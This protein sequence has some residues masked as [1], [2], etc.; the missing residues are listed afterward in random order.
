MK[1]KF[2]IAVSLIAIFTVLFILPIYFH[3]PNY[4]GSYNIEDYAELIEIGGKPERN[5]GNIGNSFQASQKGISV[6]TTQFPHVKERVAWFSWETKYEIYRDEDSQTWLVYIM[7]RS[8]YVMG[9]CYG[10][11]LTDTGEIVSCWGER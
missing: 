1:L 5:V 2:L 7:P 8:K 3:W 9:G 4:A 10:V 11:I 6:I